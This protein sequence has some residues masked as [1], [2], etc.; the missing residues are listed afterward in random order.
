[1]EADGVIYIEPKSI[2][3]ILNEHFSTI[4]TKIAN[5]LKS[6]SSTILN[7]ETTN[8]SCTFAMRPISVQFVLNDLLNLKSN[9]AV[10]MDK[11]NARFLKDAAHVIAE[12]LTNL[13]NRSIESSKFPSLWKFGKDVI[14]TT[15]DSY[16]SYLPYPRSLKRQSIANYMTI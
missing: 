10:G 5:G 9:K 6:L 2:V 16:L 14:Q 3:E 1:M 12:S 8:L 4:G 15:I 7:D 13:L 11:I